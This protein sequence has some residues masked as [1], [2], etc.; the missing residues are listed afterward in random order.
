M[1]GY[2]AC[3]WELEVYVVFMSFSIF[4]CYLLKILQRPSIEYVF[5]K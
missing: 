3:L 2:S 1:K 5:R 4:L